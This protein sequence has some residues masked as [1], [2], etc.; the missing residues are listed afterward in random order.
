MDEKKIISGVKPLIG[1]GQILKVEDDIIN[2]I[3]RYL[4]LRGFEILDHFYYNEAK[5]F[6]AAGT[7]DMGIIVGYQPGL[8]AF[9]GDCDI[10]IYV[11]SIAAGTNYQ[12]ELLALLEL[13][14]D[15]SFSVGA[16]ARHFMLRQPGNANGAGNIYSENCKAGPALLNHMH[17]NFTTMGTATVSATICFSGI[18]FILK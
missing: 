18:V 3:I 11:S 1:L 15:L 9:Y 14:S 4:K 13:K 6:S 2:S 12:V 5:V 10:D 17:C 8:I 16:W 7:W